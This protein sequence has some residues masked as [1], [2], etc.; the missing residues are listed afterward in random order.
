MDVTKELQL[1]GEAIKRVAPQANELGLSEVVRALTH[2]KG[3]ALTRKHGVIIIG[4][5]SKADTPSLAKTQ[6]YMTAA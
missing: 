1:F 6:T 5:G 3:K 2:P 4:N